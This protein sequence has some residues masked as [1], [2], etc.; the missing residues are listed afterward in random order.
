MKKLAVLG[1]SAVLAALPV[2][3][4]FAT[5]PEAVEDTL[6]ITVSETCTLTRTT[7]NGNYTATMSTN[8]LN[9]SVGSS[10]FTAVCNN[11]TGF[12]VSATPTALTGDG[13]A[14][15]YSA[16]T[17]TAGSGTWTAAKTEVAGNIAATSGVLMSTNA[18]T[19][20]LTETVTYAVSTRANQAKGDYTGTMTYQLTQN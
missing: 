4:V 2:V 20:G 9:A 7:G 13:E 17:P 14:I 10:T 1:A 5:D 3:G 8:A 11:A 6:T 16:T 18:T 15:N 12:S 19:T